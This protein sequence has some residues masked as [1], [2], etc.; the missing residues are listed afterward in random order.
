M[1]FDLCFHHVIKHEG[2][3]VAHPADPGGHTNL[4]VTKAAWEEYLGK[5]VS[6]DD[7]KA[8]T[9]EGVKGFYKT[10]YWDVI[11]GDELPPGVDYAVF[12]YA[13]NSGPAR[14]AR[15][16]QECVGATKDG[17]IGPKTIALVKE[18]DAAKLVQDVCDARLVFLQQLRHFETFGR[19]WARRVAE[20]S[21]NAV[22]MTK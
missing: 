13:V 4:G 14:A 20:V 22:E 3:Y 11:K 6:V 5:E 16:L 18:R 12:D 21:R 8:L 9:P 15:T 10:K 7:I 2:G 19:G 1:K 17:S